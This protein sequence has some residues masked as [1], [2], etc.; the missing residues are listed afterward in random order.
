MAFQNSLAAWLN[1][2]GSVRALAFYQAAFDAK[3]IY[4]FGETE[5]SIV[6]KLS[7]GGAEFWMGDEAPEHQNFSPE[8]L[9]GT[10]VRLILVVEDPDAVFARAVQAGAKQVSA[11]S[12][13]HGWRLGR[14]VDPFGYIW[15]IG[16]ETSSEP[17]PDVVP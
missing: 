6:A 13:D 11:V 16:R 4:R 12:E 5:E 3:V 2:R 9:G 14:V 8:S 17:A 10:T 15:E 7:I 1:V